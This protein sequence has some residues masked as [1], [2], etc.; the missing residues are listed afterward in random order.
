MPC[1]SDYLEPNPLERN[2]SRALLLLS[3]VRTGRHVDPDSSDWQGHH[4]AVYNREIG[5]LR[6]KL[7]QTVK[8]LC[9]ALSKWSP[10][11]LGRASLE[12]QIWWREHGKADAVR[13][14]LEAEDRNKRRLKRDALKKLTA[15]ERR[16]LGI[17][18][19]VV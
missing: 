6:V 16:A 19:D 15:A 18:R 17:K 2:L 11:K 8:S 14:R 12:L 10:Q 9:Q 3:E 13:K 5:G 4:E 1:N 7:D